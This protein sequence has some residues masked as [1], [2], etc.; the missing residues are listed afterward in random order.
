ME[1]VAQNSRLPRRK[2]AMLFALSSS[3]GKQKEQRANDLLTALWQEAILVHELLP[4]L[5]EG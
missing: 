2:P 5:F 3:E 1:I 4:R